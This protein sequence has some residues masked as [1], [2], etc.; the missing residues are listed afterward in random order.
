MAGHAAR[1]PCDRAS[2]GS[3]GSSILLARGRRRHVML[4]IG[5][6]AY[7]LHVD[8]PP[9]FPRWCHV[10]RRRSSPSP[11][12]GWRSPRCAHASAASALADVIILPMA[13]VSDVFIPIEDPPQLARDAR[14][15]LPLKPFVGQFQETA[16]TP[17]VD[18]GIQLGQTGDRRPVGCRRRVPLPC[19]TSGGSRRQVRRRRVGD[20]RVHR[21]ARNTPLQPPR[22]R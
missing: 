13:F 3:I 7:D 14:Q 21:R 6:L 9:R 18:P 11:R 5:M 1:R 15:R 22:R 2:A 12:S 16:S 20:E 4:T 8:L 17:R 19:V 10:L